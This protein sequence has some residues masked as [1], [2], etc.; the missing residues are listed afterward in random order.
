MRRAL[1]QA[2][3]LL[4]C[5]VVAGVLG[6]PLA[7]SW[8]VTHTEVTEKIGTS[9]TTFTLSTQGHSEV[10]LGIAGTVYVPSSDGPLGIVATLDGPGDPGAGDGDLAN[11]V[12]PEMLELY[13]G[14]FHDPEAAVAEYVALVESELRRQLLVAVLFVA[15]LGGLALYGLNELLPVRFTRD[16][17]RD[18]ARLALAAVLVLAMTTG[19]AWVQ[20]R[21]SE[22]GRGPTAG[23][24]PLAA[25]D[26]TLAGG[27]TTDSPVIRALLGGALGRAQV[28]VD[29]QEAAEQQY[30]EL[31]QAGLDAQADLMT[32]PADGELAGARVERRALVSA[33]CCSVGAREELR[34]R[35]GAKGGEV[36]D[37]GD[38]VARGVLGRRP[39]ERGEQQQGGD[40]GHHRGGPEMSES[41][42]VNV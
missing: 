16:G 6:A 25:L 23:V 12:R 38:R 42:D 36:L 21:G 32:G 18:A 11:Y 28:L 22:G 1:H 33:W 5:V 24:Y 10:R 30:R 13:T 37:E 8:A 35:P 29:R 40:R 26:G 34:S 17:R 20:L 3:R 4:I 7:L 41:N 2:R 31:A 19:L 39:R 14:L 27:A 15:L 9:P